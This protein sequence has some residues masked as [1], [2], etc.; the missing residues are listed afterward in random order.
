MANIK[1]NKMGYLRFLWTAILVV[2]ALILSLPV[3]LVCLVVGL[4]NMDLRDKI[5]MWMIRA[6]FHVPL[7]AAGVKLHLSGAE[8]ILKDQAAIYIGNHQ[9][10]FDVV[11]SYAHFH[12]ITAFISKKEFGHIP[13]LSWWMR[14]AHNLFLDRSDIKK[15][16]KTILSAI[17]LAKN[18]VSICIYP[19]GTRKKDPTVD[20]LPF[21]AGSFKIAE[22]SGCPIVPMVGYNVSAIFEDHLPKITS[23]HVFIDFGEPIYIKDLE[24]EDKKHLADYV[25]NIMLERYQE[26]KKQYE[27]LDLK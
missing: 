6:F 24:P 19:E 3:L 25:R 18:G 7:W 12:R 4:F 23:E 5:V 20:M 10:F 16:M 2:I 15:G 26:L 27:E 9:S 13:I 21:H 8:N 17:D 1:G 11:I 14:L 22:K